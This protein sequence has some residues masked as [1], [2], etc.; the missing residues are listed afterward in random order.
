MNDNFHKNKQIANSPKSTP[1]FDS[2][3]KYCVD[4]GEMLDEDYKCSSCIEWKK[5]M[6]EL[7]RQKRRCWEEAKKTILD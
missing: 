1:D 5:K 6:Q 3:E 4:C 2:E 7:D